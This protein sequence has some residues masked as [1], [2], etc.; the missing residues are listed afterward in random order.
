MR[1]LLH[2]LTAVIGT[3]LPI[4]NVRCDVGD[5]GISGPAPGVGLTSTDLVR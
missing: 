4:R 3:L 5:R 2:L 1:F